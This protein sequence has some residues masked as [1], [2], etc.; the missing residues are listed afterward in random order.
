MDTRWWDQFLGTFNGACDFINSG[1]VTDIYTD[2]SEFSL[3]TITKMTGFIATYF[4]FSGFAFQHI[5]KRFYCL[6]DQ[7]KRLKGF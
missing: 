3:D 4:D 7:Q 5:N 6:K 2:S 1:P